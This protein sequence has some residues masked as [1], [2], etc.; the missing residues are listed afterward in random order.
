MRRALAVL[1]LSVALAPVGAQQFTPAPGADPLHTPLDEILDAN[2]RD[3]L[4]Y[5]RALKSTRGRL[6]RYVASLNVPAATYNGWSKPQ[7]MAFWVDAY[8]AFVLETVIDHYPI[9]GTAPG[10]PSNSIRQI[11]GAFNRTTWR[12]AGRSV[13][14]DAIENTILPPFNEPR[15]FLALGRGAVGSGR[16]RSEAY[17]GDRLERQLSDL[18][19]EFVTNREMLQI[20][21]TAGTMVVTPIV[22]WHDQA[23]VAAFDKGDAAFAARSPIER[24]IIAFIM[25]NLLPLEKDFVQ[26]NHFAVTF[27]TFDWHLNDLTGRS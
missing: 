12:A 27:G 14:L 22:S 5:Y 3:G 23:F 11:P 6:D 17:T 18:Q 2:V 13:T 24:A 4:V 16:L 8:N 20:D 19:A 1:V 26:Q 10:A 21:R 9:H 15:L 7:Q 25:P